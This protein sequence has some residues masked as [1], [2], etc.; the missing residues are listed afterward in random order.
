MCSA[1]TLISNQFD[2]QVI[3]VTPEGSIVFSMGEIGVNGNGPGQL[4]APYD[5]KEVG[6]Y[7]G[8]TPPFGDFFQTPPPLAPS[9]FAGACAADRSMNLRAMPHRR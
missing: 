6:D 4:N 3:E 1:N 8:I 2:G 5:A 7:V 9:E